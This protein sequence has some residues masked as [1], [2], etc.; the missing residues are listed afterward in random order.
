MNPPNL[1]K[2]FAK[3]NSFFNSFDEEIIHRI[4]QLTFGEMLNLT[5][6]AGKCKQKQDT[7]LHSSNWQMLKQLIIHPNSEK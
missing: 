2:I 5:N 7:I 4:S 6:E 1:L 3:V